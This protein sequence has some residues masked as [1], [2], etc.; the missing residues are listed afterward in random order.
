VSA[1]TVPH[2]CVVAW[3]DRRELSHVR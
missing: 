2:A 1:F 3:M